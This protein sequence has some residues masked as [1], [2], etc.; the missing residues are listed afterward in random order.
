MTAQG[1][2]LIDALCRL[3]CCVHA[4]FHVYV[5]ASACD[6]PACTASPLTWCDMVG[7][8]GRGPVH[9]EMS[10]DT[11]EMVKLTAKMKWRRL[12]LTCSCATRGGMH[13]ARIPRLTVSS[14][15]AR[16]QVGVSIPCTSMMCNDTLHPSHSQIN[17]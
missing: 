10:F 11:V 9:S 13:F 2:V 17:V 1:W 14:V 12:N 8:R 4:C 5:C 16:V 15:R 3:C 6:L 7:P